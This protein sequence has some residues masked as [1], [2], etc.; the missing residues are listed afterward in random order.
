VDAL[1]LARAAI[2]RAAHRRGGPVLADAWAS[3]STRVLL[4]RDGLVATRP[5]AEG[6]TELD[7]VPPLGISPQPP[8]GNLHVPVFLGEDDDGAYLALVVIEHDDLDADAAAVADLP[9]LRGRTWSTLRDVGHLL[10]DRDVDLAATGVALAAWHQRNRRCGRCGAPNVPAEA[11]WTRRCRVDGTEDYPRTDPAVIV[12]VTDDADRILLGH[13][14]R[15]P[16]RRFST[17]A[18]FVEPGESAEAAVRREVA[19]EVSVEI[20]EL[21][22]VASQPWPFPNSL[23]LAFRARALTTEIA[24]DGAEMAEARWF[25]RAELQAAVHDGDVLLPMRSSVARVL[26]ESWYG[27]PLDAGD[28]PG[29]GD[30]GPLPP[31]R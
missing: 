29:P 27:G 26:I 10:G 18:G 13:A 23:M 31:G 24:V 21:E 20:G 14:A 28:D 6:S 16:N 9:V 8:A 2:D 5:G 7:L 3:G 12:A 15:W 19:E 11:G 17:L 1:P 4:V 30:L 22:Y 25:T